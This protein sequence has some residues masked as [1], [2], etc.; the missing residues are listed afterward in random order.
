MTLLTDDIAGRRHSR[1]ASGLVLAV[2]S[3][4]SFGLSGPLAKSLLDAGWSAG[5]AVTARILI[6]AAVLVVPGVLALRGQWNLLSRNIV[7]I[8]G[9]GAVAVA[10]CQLAYFNAVGYMPVGVALLIEFTSPVVVIGWMWLRHKQSPTVKTFG[11]AALAAVGLVLVLDLVSGASLDPVG[12]LWALGA[13]VGAAVYWIMSADESNGLPPLTL[14]AGGLLCGGTILLLAGLVGIV[15]F[16]ATA[17]D[18]VLA[19][20]TLPWWVSILGLG[21][22]T[23]AL[24]YVC[25][26]AAGRRLGSRLASFVGLTE[27]LSALVFAWLLLGETPRAIQIGGGVLIL[28]GVVVVKMGE[29]REPALMQTNPGVSGA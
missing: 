13:M 19:D 18:V 17:N 12:V 15:P 26:I 7:V 22:V 5:A 8:L 1:L 20:A 25:G 6:A 2:A 28:I 3:S 21:V 11:G 27:V 16:A 29:T 14:A 4:T 23:A 10:G 24:A 9:Y